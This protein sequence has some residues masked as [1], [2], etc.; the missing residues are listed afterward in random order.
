MVDYDDEALMEL[1]DKVSLF[2]YASQTMEFRGRNDSYATHCP[3]HIDVTPSLK[4]TPSKNL[5][6]CFSCKKGGNIINWMMT[7]EHLSFEE[8]VKKVEGL[9]GV[10]LPK[11]QYCSAMKVYREAKKIATYT[12]FKVEV[13][14]KILDESA[15]EQYVDEVPQEW[16]DEGIE[17]EIMKKY[18]IMID[19]RTN[20]I[21]YPVWDKDFNLIGFKGRTRYPNFKALGI[22][23]Y[24]NFQKIGTTNYFVGMK[25]NIQNIIKKDEAIIFEGI[26]SGMKVE[27]WGYDNW[28]ASETSVIND[29]QALILIQL[30][31]KNVVIAY[32]SDVSLAQIKNTV[33]MLARY[34]NVYV[35][36][37]R[38]EKEKRLLGSPED[39][40]SPC[41]NGRDIWNT[42]YSERKKV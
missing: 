21:V 16:V 19:K 24:M 34:V 18:R 17:P 41:D 28:L 30:R 27:A 15:F 12:G 31:I 1:C 42:L 7:F 11:M 20:R 39:K 26:K 29:A 37:D 3:L 23:K 6:H 8:S 10:E 2:D 35:V 38:A 4:I 40:K 13:E 25:E 32:D 33:K 9:A 5:F 14:R 22:M 36:T